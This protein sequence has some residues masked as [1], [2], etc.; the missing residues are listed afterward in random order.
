MENGKSKDRQPKTTRLWSAIALLSLIVSAVTLGLWVYHE[1][2]ISALQSESNERMKTLQNHYNDRIEA[3]QSQSDRKIKVLQ[4][5][6]N[7]KTEALEERLSVYRSSEVSGCLYDTS[8]Q[9]PVLLRLREI[10]VFSHL[11]YKYCIASSNQ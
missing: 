4:S 5:Q 9:F 2:R 11:S 3:M 6:I 1:M 10:V 8:P 7:R